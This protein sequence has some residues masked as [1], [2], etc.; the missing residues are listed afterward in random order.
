MGTLRFA[1]F[2]PEALKEGMQEMAGGQSKL[3]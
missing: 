3:L 1:F 2:C